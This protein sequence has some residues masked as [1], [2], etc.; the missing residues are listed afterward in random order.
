MEK[1]LAS[2]QVTDRTE[3]ST[4]F[5]LQTR[6][7]RKYLISKS[8]LEDILQL[9]KANFS[10]VGDSGKLVSKYESVYFDTPDLELHKLAAV[11]RR[12]RFKLRTRTYI[13]SESSFLELKVRNSRCQT[14][15]IR[16]EIPFENRFSNPDA[17]Q[18]WI[19]NELAVHDITGPT[20]YASSLNVSFQR[21][22]LVSLTEAS[23]ITIDTSL[24]FNNISALN[25]PDWIILETKSA[26]QPSQLDRNLW[27]AGI[28]PG[29]ISKYGVGIALLN[30]ATPRNK[31][32][33]TIKMAFKGSEFESQS[34]L[35]AS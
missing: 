25:S 35:R 24:E 17:H 13:E 12:R 7:D 2:L 8:L 15:K 14:N 5:T 22:T 26:G 29:K 32:N 1:L 33:R 21:S 11:G 20:A 3:L 31:W 6:T 10:V 28:R 30:P 18:A 23:R 27:R 9:S 34:L 16:F 19:E 4:E